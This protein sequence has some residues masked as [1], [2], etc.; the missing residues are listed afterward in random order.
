MCIYC[1]SIFRNKGTKSKKSLQQS[2]GYRGIQYQSYP[3]NN[4]DMPVE[5]VYTQCQFSKN[6]LKRP[7]RLWR[8]TILHV[9]SF[10]VKRC[11][12]VDQLFVYTFR[13]LFTL[14]AVC[15]HFQLCVCLFSYLFTISVVCLHFH[16]CLQF[17]LF[18]EA[19]VVGEHPSNPSCI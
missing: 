19:K 18:I 6:S 15:L 14:S 2:Q 10:Q 12:F 13:C 11:G 4:Y 3:W 7:R 5:L 9:S 17:Q 8:S 1:S 16:L